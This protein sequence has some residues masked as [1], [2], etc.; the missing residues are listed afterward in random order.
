MNIA[1]KGFSDKYWRFRLLNLDETGKEKA[2]DI[3]D[4]ATAHQGSMFQK[5]NSM[6]WIIFDEVVITHSTQLKILTAIKPIWLT[7][8]NSNYYYDINALLKDR[9]PISKVL[10]QMQ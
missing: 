3:L 8:I 9:T 10:K 2:V 1:V 6:N 5:T 4:K 7:Q